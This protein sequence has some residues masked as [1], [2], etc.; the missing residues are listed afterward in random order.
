LIAGHFVGHSEPALLVVLCTFL[1]CLV[2]A[3][4]L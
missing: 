1:L 3:P 4:K 2:S